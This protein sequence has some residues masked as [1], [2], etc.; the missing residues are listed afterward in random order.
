MSAKHHVRLSDEQRRT[1]DLF[2]RTGTHHARAIVH[3]RI[4]LLSDAADGQR[5]AY[6]DEKIA[7]ALG[8]GTSTVARIRNRFLREGLDAALRVRKAVPA[9][10]HKIDG[11]AEAHLVALACSEAPEGYARWSVRL[12]RDRFVVLGLEEGWL[13]APVGREAVRVTLK[14]TSCARTV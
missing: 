2:T 1:L 10:P 14:K 4:L 6:A 7:A 12:L 9:R 8:C 13:E 11:A 5:P 3:A